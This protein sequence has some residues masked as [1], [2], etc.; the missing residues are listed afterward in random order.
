MGYVVENLNRETLLPTLYIEMD[1]LFSFTK[2]K[3]LIL[4]LPNVL[5]SVQNTP[6]IF[7]EKCYVLDWV[8]SMNSGYVWNTYYT[9]F[10]W[11]W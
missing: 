8:S 7:Q 11:Q 3:W 4:N 6:S 2:A 10:V 1:I 5:K 9:A